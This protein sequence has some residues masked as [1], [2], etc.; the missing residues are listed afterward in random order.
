MEKKIFN[1]NKFAEEV[2]DNA[3]N[4]G[5]HDKP[6]ESGTAIAL[7]HSELSEAL[8]DLRKGKS[9]NDIDYENC[10]GVAFELIDCIIRILD[11]L[12]S[13]NIDDIETLLLKKNEYN[14]NRPYKHGNKSF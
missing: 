10:K 3:V 11:F 14:K 9:L 12:K 8:E 2:Y 13:N 7:M 1:L 5:W 6:I 4:H